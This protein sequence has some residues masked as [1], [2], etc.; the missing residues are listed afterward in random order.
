MNDIAKREGTIS[1][2]FTTKVLAEFSAVSGDMVNFNH[3][4]KRLCQHLYVKADASLKALETKRVADNNNH[5][6]PYV[7]TNINMSK[8]A[9]DTVHR[10]E[11]GLDA[12]IPNHISIIPYWNKKL[13]KYDLELQIGYAGKDFYRRKM[14]YDKPVDIIYELVYSTDEFTP[15]KKDAENKVESYNLKIK[16]PFDRGDIIGGFGYIIYK[17]ET[18]NKLVIVTESE[19]QKAKNLAKTKTFWNQSPEAMRYKTI[20]NRTTEK[21]LIDPEKMTVSMFEVEQSEKAEF[22]DSEDVED[23]IT[24]VDFEP[25]EEHDQRNEQGETDPPDDNPLKGA[26][27]EVVVCD[28]EPPDLKDPKTKRKPNF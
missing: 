27:P 10:M 11:I 28:G 14:A 3:S 18:K 25:V 7:W 4:Q 12:L 9:I 2:R 19:F 13:N 16:K 8:L 1:E 26:G 15:I 17:D 24:D 20:V 5:L 23:E 21:L 6:A 22:K